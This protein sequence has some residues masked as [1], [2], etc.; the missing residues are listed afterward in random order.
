MLDKQTQLTVCSARGSSVS[1]RSE[2]ALLTALQA[3]DYFFKAQED[4]VKV[5]WGVT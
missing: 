4:G 5:G 3:S 1:G 2:R